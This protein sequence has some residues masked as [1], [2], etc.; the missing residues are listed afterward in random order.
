MNMLTTP[1]ART[2]MRRAA[3][4]ASLLACAMLASCASIIGARD[5]EI[6]LAKLQA[7]MERRFPLHNRALELFDVDFSRPQ[8]TLQADSDRVALSMEANIAPPFTR[9]SWHGSLGLSGRL[10]VDA[11]RGAIFMSEPRVDSFVLDGVDEGRQRQ[12]AKV[13]NV[14]MDKLMRESAVYNFRMEDLRYAGVQFVPT[15]I[16][17]TPTALVVHL[18]PAR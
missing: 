17:T 16:R 13:A 2:P 9:Q 18:E 7:G 14:L 8:L 1:S 10:S 12:F 11:A 3:I 4:L 6:P 5:V 15:A